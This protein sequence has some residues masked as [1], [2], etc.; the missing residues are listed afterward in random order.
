MNGD[1][2]AQPT[3]GTQPNEDELQEP[4]L[5]PDQLIAPPPPPD[6]RQFTPDLTTFY[7]PETPEA[8]RAAGLS[9]GMEGGIN[10]AGE[11]SNVDLRNHT[12]EQFRAGNSPF[13]AVAMA[14]KPSGE[15][16]QMNVHGQ[17]IIA[18][19]VDTGGGLRS[20]QVDV[21]TSNPRLARTGTERG[22]SGIPSGTTS[23]A[24]LGI[25]AMQ[26]AMLT[27][28]DPGQIIHADLN[29]LVQPQIESGGRAL[30][31]GEPTAASLQ[32]LQ[33]Q[34][35][36]GTGGGAG[37]VP[38]GST[39]DAAT[40][41]M[42]ANAGL[43]DGAITGDM[44]APSTRGLKYIRDNSGVIH[45]ENGFKPDGSVNYEGGIEADPRT[46]MIRMKMNGRIL[47]WSNPLTRPTNFPDPEFKT[48]KDSMGNLYRQ[49]AKPGEL[50]P[51][52]PAGMMPPL[53]A[54]PTPDMSQQDRWNLALGD[55]NPDQKQTVWNLAY[56]KSPVTA[57]AL[58]NPQMNSMVNRASV[59]NP[60]FNAGYYDGIKLML[61]GY[62]QQKA[63]TEGGVIR[64]YN[65][66]LSHINTLSEL[67]KELHN[68]W[69]PKFNSIQQWFKTEAGQRWKPAYDEASD[70]VAH[71]AARAFNG[72]AAPD[73]AD[74]NQQQG[75]LN[76]ARSPDQ[77]DQ[78]RKTMLDLI[79]GGLSTYDQ[80][81]ENVMG[82]PMD[83]KKIIFPKSKE[84]L[85]KMGIK[86]FADRQLAPDGGAGA[87]GGA[88]GA[89]SAA[90]Q[91]ATAELT[92]QGKLV[93]PETI[94]QTIK[95]MQGQQ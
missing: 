88:A 3:L 10:G 63:G 58:R 45:Y 1:T 87:Q 86:N 66:V 2:A 71:E 23:A 69:N 64:G 65:Q 11:F 83:E 54:N 6:Y 91:A 82:E 60:K 30:I 70:A 68:T 31:A 51:I 62:A 25:T 38:D 89:G 94:K 18:K 37:A 74:I 59:I 79:G 29:A 84:I 77:F 43:L 8:T 17:P 19:N 85:L 73:Q 53:Q 95:I 50:I 56:Y 90:E 15:M 72:G 44:P 55:L 28:K 52:H 47:V 48:I 4:K 16:F 42:T 22:L 34:A 7:Y 35:E 14:G 39:D 26:A 76:S 92:R 24:P 67:A 32:G 46:K 27:G 41:E 13:V 33:D 9:Y 61:R 49:G 80:G 81:W 20:G 75:P 21:A 40:D 57:A 93:N 36:A 78:V 12:L 5:P